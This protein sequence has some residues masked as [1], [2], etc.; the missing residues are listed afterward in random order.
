M[1]RVHALP[2]VKERYAG[3]GLEAVSST[4]EVYAEFIKAEAAR[5]SR[6]VSH[7]LHCQASASCFGSDQAKIEADPA[8]TGGAGHR[9]PG[10]ARDRA[11][12]HGPLRLG[13]LWWNFLPG[14]LPWCCPP[15]GLG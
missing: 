4:P 8:L 9:R 12:A 7:R 5:S 11:P 2:D 1:V 6:S 13:G 15:P 3:L 14:L 10:P